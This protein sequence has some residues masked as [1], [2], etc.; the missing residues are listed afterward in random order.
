MR[1]GLEGETR[2]ARDSSGDETS[3]ELSLVDPSHSASL[4]GRFRHRSAR[5]RVSFIAWVSCGPPR[6]PGTVIANAAHARAG[7]VFAFGPFSFD[8]PLA[9]APDSGPRPTAHSGMRSGLC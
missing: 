2:L 1:H 6:S 5:S 8:M 9:T 7:L 4:R 3:P